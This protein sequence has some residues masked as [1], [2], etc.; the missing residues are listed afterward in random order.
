MRREPGPTYNSRALI[1][2]CKPFDWIDEFPV[3][4]ESS[5]EYLAKYQQEV[6]VSFPQ[7]KRLL[8]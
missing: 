2:T 1:D 4:A 6:A 5:A 7:L 8:C 3:V